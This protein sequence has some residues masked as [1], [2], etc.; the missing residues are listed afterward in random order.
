[1]DYAKRFEGGTVYQAFLD[2]WTYHRWHSPVDGVV[3][4]VYPI[5]GCYYLQNPGIIDPDSD[6]DYI[7][8]QPFLTCTST[9][10]IFIIKANNPKIGSIGIIF[11]GM[12]EVSSCVT[13]LKAGDC[14]KKG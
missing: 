14:V 10:L 9:R 4:A 11:V 5:K 1:M 3:E 7:N 6:D 12:A 13:K 8:S 2:P